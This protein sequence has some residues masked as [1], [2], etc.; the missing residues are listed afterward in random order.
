MHEDDNIRRIC[1]AYERLI[2]AIVKS[3]TGEEM[4]ELNNEY[5]RLNKKYKGNDHGNE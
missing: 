1:D 4:I 3:L 5:L 2:I